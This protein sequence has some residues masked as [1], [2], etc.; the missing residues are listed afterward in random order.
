MPYKDPQKKK[1]Y[2]KIWREKNL[3]YQK[4]YQKKLMMENPDEVRAKTRARV[5][6]HRFR[7]KKINQE[8][9]PLP[10]TNNK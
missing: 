8:L 4:V 1:E 2:Q 10:D 5:F 9:N 6:M 7:K 3:A